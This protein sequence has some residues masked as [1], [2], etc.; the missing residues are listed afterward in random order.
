MF[1]I[2]FQDAIQ[3]A[4]DKDQKLNLLLGNGFSIDFNKSIFSQE[5]IIQSAINRKQFQG[6]KVLSQVVDTRRTSNFEELVQNI[7]SYCS[8][9]KEIEEERDKLLKIIMEELSYCHPNSSLA[10]TDIESDQCAKFLSNFQAIYTTNYD[11]LLY[12]VIIKENLIDKFKDGFCRK[13]FIWAPKENNNT[14]YLHGGLHLYVTPDNKVA[15]YCFS[16]GKSLKTQILAA[17]KENKF[18]ISVSGGT[19]QEK[20]EI[21]NQ[22]KYL[23]Y[24]LE[25]LEN[26]DGSLFIHG[27]NFNQNDEHIIDAITHSKIKKLFISIHSSNNKENIVNAIKKIEAFRNQNKDPLEVT[28]YTA[29]TAE[30]WRKVSNS[31]IVDDPHVIDEKARESITI[32]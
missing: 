32:N 17:L 5:E 11:L 25:S 16:E 20:L 14:Y 12:W 7:R 30:I 31:V 6:E 18:P 8:L 24:A 13:G 19:F 27:F 1:T 3:K 26:A 15:K 22:C 29:E 2:S 28:F 10:I 9:L 23:E 4:K 21:I